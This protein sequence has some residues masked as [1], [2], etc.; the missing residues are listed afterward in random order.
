MNAAHLHLILVHLPIVAVPLLTAILC[1]GIKWESAQLSKV[2]LVLLVLVALGTI[3]AYL[4]GE[5]AEELVENLPGIVKDAIEKHED[6]GLIAF[7]ITTPVALAALYWQRVRV[8]VTLLGVV[9]SLLLFQAGY[10]G[11]EI[12]HSEEIKKVNVQIEKD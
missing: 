12:R 6:A 5:G 2:A 1:I 8:A 4:T 3:P 11:G 10:F 9:T 7:M